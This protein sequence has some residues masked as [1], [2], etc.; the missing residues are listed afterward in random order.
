MVTVVDDLTKGTFVRHVF[1][2]VSGNLMP[3]LFELNFT[4]RGIKHM[5]KRSFVFCSI[6]KAALDDPD[7]QVY[8]LT[9]R[10]KHEQE[11]YPVTLNVVHTVQK[12]MIKKGWLTEVPNQISRDG[13]A[14]R[15]LVSNKLISRLRKN[16]EWED[17]LPDRPKL[18]KAQTVKIKQ[19]KLSKYLRINGYRLPER[20]IGR[21]QLEDLRNE[22][23]LVNQLAFEHTFTGLLTIKGEPKTFRGFN[24]T[25]IHDLNGSGRTY[26]GCEQMKEKD[27]LNIL[28]DG[29]PVVEIDIAA[30]QPTILWSRFIRGQRKPHEP[31]PQA[32]DFYADVVVN[33]DHLLDREQ[34]KAVITKALGN[35]SFPRHRWPYGMKVKGHKWKDVA[36]EF[37]T[38]MPFLD[39][40]EPVKED[41]FTLQHTEAQIIFLTMYR[42]YKF[43]NVPCLPVHDA[44]VVPLRHVEVAEDFLSK[45]FELATGVVP[46]L[47]IKS[48]SG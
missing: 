1:K 28:I 37:I 14:K 48:E 42:L 36:N 18:T 41:S 33:T 9:N 31:V 22:V 20:Q 5:E 8:W 11:G 19:R 16:L 47:R 21:Q 44:I 38:A 10:D 26:G 30:C 25:F 7:H 34:V 3:L 17:V 29:E 13:Y 45:S 43:K 27:R 32:R 23:H 24:R 35:A 40:L 12:A 4:S 2:E 39:L 15:W 46:K 6:C